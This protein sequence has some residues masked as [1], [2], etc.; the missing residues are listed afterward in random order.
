M[1]ENSIATLSTKTNVY[2]ANIWR[3]NS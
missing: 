2:H 1:N 3:G